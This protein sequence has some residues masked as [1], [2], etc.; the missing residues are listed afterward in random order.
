MS[1]TDWLQWLYPILPFSFLLELTLAGLLV[2]WQIA[3]ARAKRR[4]GRGE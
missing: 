2:R 4:R 3:R 1:A